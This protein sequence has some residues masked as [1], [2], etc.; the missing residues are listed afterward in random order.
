MS[1]FIVH[2][3]LIAFRPFSWFG[4]FVTAPI[5]AQSHY[6]QQLFGGFLRIGTIL[7]LKGFHLQE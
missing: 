7:F 5:L 6:L 3:L 2:G 4:Q 1:H